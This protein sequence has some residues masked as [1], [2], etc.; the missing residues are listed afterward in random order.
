MNC[1]RL[2]QDLEATLLATRGL[3]EPSFAGIAT[4]LTRAVPVVLSQGLSAD[5]VSASLGT[6]SAET[7]LIS[8]ALKNAA[9]YTEEPT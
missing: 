2:I 6:I 8:N 1:G 5:Q 7:A 9:R 3:L 4:L